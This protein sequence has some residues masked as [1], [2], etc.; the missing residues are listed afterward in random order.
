M[1][2]QSALKEVL[3]ADVAQQ[4]SLVEFERLRFDFNL[5]RPM[6]PA[7]VSQVDAL[8]NGWIQ[9]RCGGRS[10]RSE[11]AQRLREC[12]SRTRTPWRPL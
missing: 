11:S 5:P 1:C 2:P 3:G 6:T 8:V 10:Q 12:A 9:V 4:G 7:E